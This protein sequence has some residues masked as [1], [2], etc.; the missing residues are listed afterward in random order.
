MARFTEA[1]MEEDLKYQWKGYQHDD[2]PGRF[3]TD[4]QGMHSLNKQKSLWVLSVNPQG[5]SDV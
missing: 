5:F 1:A 4:E 3:K 2:Y